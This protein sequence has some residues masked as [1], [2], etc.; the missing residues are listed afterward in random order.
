VAMCYGH[1]VH[2]NA[3][4]HLSLSESCGLLIQTPN[5]SRGLHVQTLRFGC[6]LLN[7]MS[8]EL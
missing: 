7:A 1:V 4:L 6:L 5:V 8:A 2:L 3:L